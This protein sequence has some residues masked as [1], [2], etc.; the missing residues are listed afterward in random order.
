M[1][2]E[3][4][5]KSSSGPIKAKVRRSDG[6]FILEDGSRL[7]FEGRG[8]ARRI[9]TCVHSGRIKSEWEILEPLTF[10]VGHW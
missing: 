5:I 4:V 8:L 1:N 7:Q 2:M 6:S 3:L 10:P 9:S